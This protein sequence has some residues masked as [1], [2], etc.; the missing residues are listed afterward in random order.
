MVKYGLKVTASPRGTGCGGVGRC[1]GGGV[2]R[3]A[4][5][6]VKKT[7]EKGPEKGPFHLKSK[8]EKEMRA[9]KKGNDNL[10]TYSYPEEEI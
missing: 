2:G 10:F 7:L 8:S 6:T 3:K 9:G 5:E 1:W 4:A